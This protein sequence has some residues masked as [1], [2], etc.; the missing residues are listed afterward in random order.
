MFTGIIEEV[1]SVESLQTGTDAL[2]ISVR[3][4]KVLEESA[5][6]SS[7]AVNGVCLTAESLGPGF[8]TASISP[9]TARRSHLAGLAMGDAVNL[10]RPLQAGGRLG[11]HIVLG[12]VD[13]TGRVVA[14]DP[15]GGGHWW[16]TVRFPAELDPYLVFK[17]SIA[18]D[19]ISLTIASLDADTFSAAVVPHTYAG[20]TLSRIKPG[21]VVNLETD[22]IARHVAKL[23]GH[24][25]KPSG[26]TLEKLREA[27]F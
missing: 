23:Y 9:E 20:T 11:G 8:F 17:G 2:S 22:I 26:L 12:H 14:L 10:E 7:I 21:A 6:G 19:G 15:R 5:V 3:C 18:V 25:E 16:L 1:G 24:L 27:G 4:R 13:G